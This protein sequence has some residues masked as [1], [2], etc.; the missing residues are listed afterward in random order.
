MDKMAILINVFTV[1][2]DETDRFLALWKEQA[3][4]MSAQPGF[5]RARLHR[6]TRDDAEYRFIN[7]AEWASEELFTKAVSNPEFV[8]LANR[9]L[10]GSGL[11]IT[12]QPA[13]YEV[14]VDLR[15]GQRVDGTSG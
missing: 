7:V 8:S 1:P 4:I 12:A 2:R 10:T 9:M 13:I 3:T 11:H 14:V 5:V 15:P 6:A